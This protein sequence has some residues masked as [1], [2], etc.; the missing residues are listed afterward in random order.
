[1]TYSDPAYSAAPARY[2]TMT[3]RRAGRSGLKLPAISLGLWHN[4]GDTRP[5]ERQRAITA[6]HPAD[7]EPYLQMRDSS[8]IDQTD[9]Q[10]L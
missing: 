8:A 2:D 1:V 9:K 4:F 6:G 3:Y 5:L 10:Q 7:S